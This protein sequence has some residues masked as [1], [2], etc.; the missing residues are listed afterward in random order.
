MTTTNPF[1]PRRSCPAHRRHAL[2]LARLATISLSACGGADD[3]KG[4]DFS[5]VSESQ[6]DAVADE[7]NDRPRKRLAFANPTE[8]LAELLLH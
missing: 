7:L 1:S 3:D 2:V 4:T 8:Q 6:L 5:A